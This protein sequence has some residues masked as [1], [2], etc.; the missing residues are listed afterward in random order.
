MNETPTCVEDALAIVG[1]GYLVLPVEM[2]RRVCLLLGLPSHAPGLPIISWRDGDEAWE[3][4][5]IAGREGPGEGVESV[6]LS[7]Y[8][9]A[10]LGIEPA[11]G[12]AIGNQRV[13]NGTR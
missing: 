13:T 10:Q 2:A 9:A 7:S 4:C 5:G 3:K 11:P 8:V 6:T 12:A 1:D